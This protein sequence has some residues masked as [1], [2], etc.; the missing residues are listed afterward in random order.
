PR[1]APRPSARTPSESGDGPWATLA[2]RLLVGLP[3]G[4]ELVVLRARLWRAER[5][6]GLAHCLE[7]R[8][9]LGIAGVHVRVVLPG[10]LPERLL[11]LLLGRGLGDAKD[12]VVVA[13][14]HGGLTSRA[15]R[16]G[17]RVPG[18]AAGSPC[19]I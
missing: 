12:G 15:S 3:V 10:E 9:G 14:V 11:D 4:A 19:E 17:D 1:A 5:L 2:G 18:S 6:I 8:L 13:E 7:A 16:S